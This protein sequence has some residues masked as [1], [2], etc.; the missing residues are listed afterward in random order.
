MC[1]VHIRPTIEIS[2]I[3]VFLPISSVLKWIFL[4]CIN[5]GFHETCYRRY[6]NAK[7]LVVDIAQKRN[8]KEDLSVSASLK[9]HRTRSKS[10]LRSG[11]LPNRCIIYSKVNLTITQ[12]GKG[13]KDKLVQAETSDGG[14]LDCKIWPNLYRRIC[15]NFLYLFTTLKLII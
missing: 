2:T 9:K 4:Y 3:S 15:S 11:V 1:T 8:M 14:T 5:S 7:W 12:K 10:R 13:I 6:I